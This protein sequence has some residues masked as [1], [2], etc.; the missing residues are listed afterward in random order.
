MFTIKRTDIL[1]S[2]YVGKSSQT[3]ILT[4]RMSGKSEKQQFLVSP[5]WNQRNFEHFQDL[6]I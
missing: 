4:I 3:H 1:L 2:Q 5:D 6:P